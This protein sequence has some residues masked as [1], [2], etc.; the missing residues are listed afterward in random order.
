VDLQSIGFYYTSLFVESTY[1]SFIGFGT[2]N[3]FAAPSFQLN[4]CRSVPVF[5]FWNPV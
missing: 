1:F 2:E 5:C 4:R 3:D